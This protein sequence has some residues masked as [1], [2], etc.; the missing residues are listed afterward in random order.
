MLVAA[1]VCLSSSA[2][3]QCDER[4]VT[5][6]ESDLAA[7]T[8]AIDIYQSDIDSLRQAVSSLAAR[9]DAV[10]PRASTDRAARRELDRLLRESRT[11]STAVD[12]LAAEQRSERERGAPIAAALRACYIGELQQV[13]SQLQTLLSADQLDAARPLV[14]RSSELELKLEDLDARFGEASDAASYPRLSEEFI[15][16]SLTSVEQRSLV[17]GSMRDLLDGAQRDSL[18]ASQ[19]V[20]ETGQRVQLKTDLL[21]L[22]DRRRASGIG[23]GGFFEEFRREE[24]ELEVEELRVAQARWTAALRDAT[25]AMAYYRDRVALLERLI[26]E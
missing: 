4:T 12:K 9:A 25:A 15:R 21:K 18:M 11:L 23:D 3:A 26:R 5:R 14:Q 19:R 17:L 22:L 10:R 20:N 16:S 7:I 1:G 24:I 8:S 6:N 2:H 13:T